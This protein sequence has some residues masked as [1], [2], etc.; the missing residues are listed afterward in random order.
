VLYPLLKWVDNGG[1]VESWP[2]VQD[3]LVKMK[4][5]MVIH[6]SKLQRASGVSPIAAKASTTQRVTSASTVP[7]KEVKEAEAKSK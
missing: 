1:V 6:V 7:P 4:D 5:Q 3:T 2:V